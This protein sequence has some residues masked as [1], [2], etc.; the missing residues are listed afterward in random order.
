MEKKT[1][2]SGLSEKVTYIHLNTQGDNSLL[3]KRYRRFS[4]IVF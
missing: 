2:K 1:C 3:T 4:A